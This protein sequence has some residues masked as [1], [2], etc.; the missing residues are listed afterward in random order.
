MSSKDRS[1]VFELWDLKV[2]PSRGDSVVERE[3]EITR[4]LTR[5]VRRRSLVGK[6]RS[7]IGQR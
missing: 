7:L 2:E 3:E 4:L 6:M 5:S 1:L